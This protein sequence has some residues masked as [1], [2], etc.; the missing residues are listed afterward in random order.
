[1][2]KTISDA[3][4]RALTD[5][6]SD[7]V[8]RE[9][10][11][12]HLAHWEKGKYVHLEPTIARLFHDPIPM[13]RGAAIKA[14]VGTWHLTDHVDE[15]LKMMRGD[16]DWS[17]RADAAFAVGSYAKYTG[18]ERERIL[19]AL[20]EAVRADEDPAV[21]EAAYE[22]VLALL[23]RDITWSAGEFDRDRNVDWELLQPHLA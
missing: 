12:R 1:M 17:V 13:V 14:L 2:S 19:K 3:D 6:N 5:P 18:H 22:Q 23:E 11:L 8:D 9:A 16:S 7:P 20:A 10:A 4:V 21:Q 15:A